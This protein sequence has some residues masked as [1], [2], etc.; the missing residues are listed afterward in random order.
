MRK[1]KIEQ[2]IQ[3]LHMR[4]RQRLPLESPFIDVIDEFMATTIEEANFHID[5]FPVCSEN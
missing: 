5:P 1:I 4:E 3:S 2:L